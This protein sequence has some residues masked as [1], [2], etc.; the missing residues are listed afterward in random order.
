MMES[1]SHELEWTLFVEDFP[2][3][4]YIVIIVDLDQIVTWIFVY[5]V[6]LIL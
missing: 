5:S 3:V 2:K 4:T 6:F 1:P